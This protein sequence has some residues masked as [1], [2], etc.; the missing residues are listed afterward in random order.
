MS[1]LLK[2][3]I[4][5]L[6]LIFFTCC[7]LYSCGS[8]PDTET[9]TTPSAEGNKNVT[10]PPSAD[11]KDETPK[12]DITNTPV[13]TSSTAPTS[14]PRHHA[15][16][17]DNLSKGLAIELDIAMG[18]KVDVMK[19][20]QLSGYDFVGCYDSQNKGG[21]L[22]IDTDGLVCAEVVSDV[23]LYAW[24]T[25]RNYTLSFTCN[26]KNASSFGLQNVNAAYDADIRE[27][28]P[29][30]RIVNE[31]ELI[32]S[33]SYGGRTLTDI[34]EN[35]PI[36][37]NETVFDV[38]TFTSAS[39]ITLDLKTVT[40]YQE[41][42][43]GTQEVCI[44]DAFNQFEQRFKD[45]YICD[46]LS[47]ENIDFELLESLGFN[48]AVIEITCCMREKDDGNQEIYVYNS[49]YENN[50]SDTKKD[51]K[52]KVKT[53]EDFLLQDKSHDCEK[54]DVEETT[55]FPIE[56][57]LSRLKSGTGIYVYY[58]ASGIGDDDWYRVYTNI[59]VTFEQRLDKK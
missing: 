39:N 2:K 59:K 20:A 56:V 41:K 49:A 29:L 11:Q 38:N 45:E 22:Y 52:A 55:T 24:Y 34:T 46:A 5:Y 31:T 32:Y 15:T 18:D 9:N 10:A 53:M 43:F 27:F 23:T 40:V 7:F 58:G 48:N 6:F 3:K 47:F 14:V 57:S 42:R 26:G 1:H 37:L 36:L 33:V 28:L 19:F 25:P 4:Q 35:K 30:N 17:H 12:S 8:Q 50:P 54:K 16:I 44:K 13:P 21:E 51:K